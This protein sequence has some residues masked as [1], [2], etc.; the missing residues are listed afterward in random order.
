MSTPDNQLQSIRV[1]TPQR[2]IVEYR[3]CSRLILRVSSSLRLSRLSFSCRNLMEQRKTDGSFP[4]KIC[5]ECKS[6]EIIS[7]DS[8]YGKKTAE[9]VY[10]LSV[11]TDICIGIEDFYLYLQRVS[12]ETRTLLEAQNIT[13]LPPLSIKRAINIHKRSK[14]AFCAGVSAMDVGCGKPR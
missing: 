5:F 6:S 4:K 7:I 12:K 14:C 8:I 2:D 1:T 13:E 11:F 9:Y 10:I 3:Q